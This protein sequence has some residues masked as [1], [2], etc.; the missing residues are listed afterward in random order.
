[1]I[2]TAVQTQFRDIVADRFGLRFD[3][4]RLDFLGDLLQRRA[5][6]RGLSVGDYLSR[7]GLDA[8][9]TGPL[10]E[11]LTVGETYFFRDGEQFRALA[12]AVLPEL[13]RQGNAGRTLNILSAGCSSGEEPYTIAMLAAGLAP[14]AGRPISIRA[15]DINPAALHKARTGR[16]GSWALRETPPDMRQRWFAPQGREMA[17][18]PGLK[19]GIRF[20]ECNLLDADSDLWL[21]GSYDVVFC[22]N[23]IMYFIPAVQRAV[24]ARIADALV[25]G[26]YLFLGHA[27]T[28]RGLSDRFRL[29]QAHGTFFYRREPIGPGRRGSVPAP[30]A[31]KPRAAAPG[32]K[33]AAGAAA[34]V[35]TD[36]YEEILD[37]GRRIE[38]LAR[39]PTALPDAPHP[40]WRSEAMLEL[41][42]RERFA[43]ALAELDRLQPEAAADP[44]LVLLRAVLLAQGGALAEARDNCRRLLAR[45][46]PN[47]GANYV[48][49]LCDEG[50]GDRIAALRHYAL[51]AR[52]DPRFAMPLV[53]GGM[54][55]R[56][57]GRLEEAR[58]QLREA[59]ELLEREETWRL[60]LF[61]GGF[62]RT[63][64]ARLCAAELAAC[65]GAD[66]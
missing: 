18:S 6:A 25:P 52:L 44:E 4:G 28:L 35:N 60:L 51:A 53:R 61:G 26:G 19:R 17:V 45:D 11:E 13:Q 12:D 29:E 16:Y 47:A 63:A 9:E 41:L 34:D 54:L 27:E 66:A 57:A 23:V 22:R 24:V 14:G 1:V 8:A 59:I 48:L 10:A 64:L 50:G 42:R 3:D 56:R 5:D 32:P 31:D 33:V 65:G 39:P 37:A 2:A 62:T 21:P 30:S 58:R 40:G 20:E 38:V 43:E 46:V 49:A 15:V 36:W 7:V 55:M